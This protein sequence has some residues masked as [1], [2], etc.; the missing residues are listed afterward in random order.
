VSEEI[1]ALQRSFSS[2]HKVAPQQVLSSIANN[3]RSYR[4]TGF[5]EVIVRMVGKPELTTFLIN[6]GCQRIALSF[7][8]RN[9]E[10]RPDYA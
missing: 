8:A 2:L 1:C 4:E 6:C 5:W 10:G 9:S 3:L 7:F